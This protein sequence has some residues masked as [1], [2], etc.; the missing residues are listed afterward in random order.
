MWG[1]DNPLK[2]YD[3]IYEPNL[4]KE[5][6][7]MAIVNINKYNTFKNKNKFENFIKDRTDITMESVEIK[8]PNNPVKL[9]EAKLIKY[10]L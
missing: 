3:Y 8:D 1:I 4:D 6:N 10:S 9:I 7:F 2:V 5:F